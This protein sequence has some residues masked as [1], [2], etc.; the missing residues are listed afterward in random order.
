MKIL[1]INAGSSSIK[2]KVFNKADLSEVASITASDIGEIS[3]NIKI[4]FKDKQNLQL[5]LQNHHEA[6]SKILK[7]LT[8][9]KIINS[10]NEIAAIGHRVVHG[11][12][13]YS[14]PIIIDKNSIESIKELIPLAPLHNPANL[15]GIEILHNLAKDISQVAVFDTAFHQT[16]PKSSYTYALPHEICDKYHIRRYGFHGTSHKFVFDKYCQLSNSDKN[17]T[18]AITLHLGNG[19]SVAAIK[20][21]KCYDTSMGYTPLEG[22][23]MG[24]RC[25]DIDPAIV[26][27][28]SHEGYSTDEIDKIL[29]KKSGLLG[30]CGTNN[31]KEVLERDDNDAKE[32]FEIFTYRIKKYI[33]AYFSAL[34]GC[35]A[36]IFTGG[37]GENSAKTREAVTNNLE[38]LGIKIDKQ[39]NENADFIISGDD[40]KVKI[41]IIQT[42]EE[43]EIAKQSIE[44]I[45]NE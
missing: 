10:I 12:D 43:L 26:I 5:N 38:A 14:T 13:R 31:L 24:S 21:G 11:G 34:N 8:E 17:S 30:L 7:L 22:L 39:R 15:L 23:V 9:L 35:E 27:K 16:M 3:S 32:A 37:I 29:N 19:A 4:N 41:C 45:S 42:N 36:I 25:G 2:V 6:L 20:D 18:S 44:A 28:L 1:V 40:S 33:G